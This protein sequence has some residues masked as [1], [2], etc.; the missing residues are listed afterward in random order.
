MYA[1]GIDIGASKIL[2]VVCEV[3]RE[4]VKVVRQIKIITPST[5]VAFL[6]ELYELLALLMDS[7]TKRSITHAGVAVAGIFDHDGVLRN[8][9]NMPFLNGFNVQHYFSKKIGVPVRAVNDARAFLSYSLR[10]GVARE[11]NDVVGVVLGS[12]VG[13][14]IALDRRIVSGAHHSAGEVGHMII[15]LETHHKKW[16]VKSLEALASVKALTRLGHGYAQVG[17]ALG[18]GFANIVNIIDPDMIVVGGGLASAG[19]LILVRAR[20]VMEQYIVSPKARRIPV[21]IEK[22]YEVA[23]AVGAVL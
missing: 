6:H 7:S 11:Q 20:N 5:R 2:G 4:R 14:A 22:D 19:D 18:I 21:V 13:G 8:S 17:D 1:L 12:G 9:P 3:T 23:S 15:D 10:Y 16:N